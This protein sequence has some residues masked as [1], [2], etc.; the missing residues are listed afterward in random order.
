MVSKAAKIGIAVAV[1]ATIGGVAAV[2]ALSPKG[3]S[4]TVSPNPVS[5]GQ[6]LS[7]KAS[8]LTPGDQVQT[9]V[10]LGTGG[11]IVLSPNLT[12]GADGTISA[13]FT[14]GSN[15]PTGQNTLMV[16]DQ[17]TGASAKATFTVT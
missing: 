2:Y 3:P 10:L 12:V 9:V 11:S 8:G 17:G 15:I 7:W 13:S 5:Q 16:T 4:L 6:T 1:L 14:V